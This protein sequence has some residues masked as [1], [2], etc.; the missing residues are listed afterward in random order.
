MKD[1]LNEVGGGLST[2]P[3]GPKIEVV[4]L[5][6]PDSKIEKEELKLEEK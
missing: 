1:L 5:H 6:P 2:K 4:E 3:P